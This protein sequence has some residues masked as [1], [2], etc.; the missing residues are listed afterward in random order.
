MSILDFTTGLFREPANLRS[1]CR[2][3]RPGAAGRRP[4]RRHPRTGPRP[5]PMVAESMPPDHPLQ[6]V[7]HAADPFAALRARHRRAGSPTVRRPQPGGGAGQERGR[8]PERSIAVGDIASPNR[9][10]PTTTRSR[11]TRQL[12]PGPPRATRRLGDVVDDPL[13]PE[14]EGE[15]M[16]EL[17][18][19]TRRHDD[20]VE[21]DIQSSVAW[22]KAIE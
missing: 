19:T 20:L 14:N 8:A 18:S 4:S 21:P 10:T 17:T 12:G 11:A 2:R 3:P 22:G 5:P 16:A 13:T 7:V 1:L 15:P 9:S 6:T